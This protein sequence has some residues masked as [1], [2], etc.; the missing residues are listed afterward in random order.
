[1]HKNNL[2]YLLSGHKNTVY[3]TYDDIGIDILSIIIGDAGQ[4][5]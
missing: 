5:L 3:I 1:M 2:F 4:L